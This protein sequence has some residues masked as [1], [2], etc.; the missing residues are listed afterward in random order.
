MEELID[1]S[2][3]DYKDEIKEL[4]IF[5]DIQP[6]D[7]PEFLNSITESE[8]EYEEVLIEYGDK[9]YAIFITSKLYDL[10][11][12]RVKNR[13]DE[14]RYQLNSI[15][16]GLYDFFDEAEYREEY[17]VPIEVFADDIEESGDFHICSFTASG[18]EYYN[19]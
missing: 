7:V 14:I 2:E 6:D 17:Y 10:L 18:G 5:L 4:C 19:I 1:N 8:G 11:D 16:Y 13:L 3:F 15:S 12:D 9:L